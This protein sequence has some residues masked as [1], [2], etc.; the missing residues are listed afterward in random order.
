[1]A[2]PTPKR[3]VDTAPFKRVQPAMALAAAHL[4]DE[5]PLATLSAHAGLSAF[6]LHRM[7]AAVA[8]ETPK[9]FTLRLRLSRGAARL[10]SSDDS[11]RTL[12]SRAAF[13][14]TKPLRGRSGG[15]SG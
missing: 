1:M 7:F 10:L 15:G 13:R 6:H 2:R 9:Q 3:T 12:P 14:A 8:G 4:D 5:L 11:V